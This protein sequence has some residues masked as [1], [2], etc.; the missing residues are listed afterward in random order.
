MKL[1]LF[2]D[3]H[4]ELL[5][6]ESWQPPQLDVDVVILAGDVGRQ[7]NGMEWAANAFRQAPV[8]PDVLYV[9]GNHEY[10]DAGLSL[11][12]EFQ[13][14]HW[15][16]MGVHFLECCAYDWPGVRVLGC[17]LWSGFS[18]HG[19]EVIDAAMDY[20]GKGINDYK[21]IRTE[22]GNN[23]LTP[24]DTLQLHQTSAHWL[25]AELGKPFDGRTVVVTHF[26]PHRRCVPSQFEGSDLSPYFVTDLA[27]LMEKH[28]IDVWCFGHTHTNCDF[29][30]E[31][32]C[33]VVSNQL[34]YQYERCDGFRPELIIE[35]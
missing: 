22:G 6:G 24:W 10:Y 33:R 4:L 25:D 18:L 12:N 34:G 27:W 19:M 15:E 21:L 2:S 20:A 9:A 5:D 30:A 23:I 8:S 16:K 14:P 32:G 29:V 17:T 26:A 35:L 31:N 28:R 11:L 3:L 1:A 7:T 13:R